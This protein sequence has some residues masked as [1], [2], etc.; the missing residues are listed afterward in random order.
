M[1]AERLGLTDEAE[2]RIS[3][4]TIQNDEGI[5]RS[6][7]GS[8][9]MHSVAMGQQKSPPRV[10]SLFSGAGGLDLRLEAAGF[11]TRLCVELDEDARATLKTNR[12]AWTIATPGDIH[13][14]DPDELLA[15]GELRRA[16]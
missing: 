9:R 11:E 2:Q 14:H 12:P 13:A 1:N 5:S 7:C 3:A 8:L 10:L 16:R 6:R 15:Q 4:L